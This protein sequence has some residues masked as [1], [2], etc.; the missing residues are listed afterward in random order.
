M[1]VY[2]FITGQAKRAFL[3]VNQERVVSDLT[4]L[5]FPTGES[6]MGFYFGWGL[7]ITI[8]RFIMVPLEGP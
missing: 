8:V 4:N 7:N 5:A 2:E 6:G 1:F 3:T